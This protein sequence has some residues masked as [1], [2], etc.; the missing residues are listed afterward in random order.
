[1]V[2]ITCYNYILVHLPVH[3][4]SP[5]LIQSVSTD[6][7]LI[8]YQQ[9]YLQYIKASLLKVLRFWLRGNGK[10]IRKYS[11]PPLSIVLHLQIQP[12]V[13]QKYSGKK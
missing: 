10:Q 7:V 3:Y 4:S 9:T 8:I 2:L 12:T 1:M 13:N 6:L 5:P 11:Q